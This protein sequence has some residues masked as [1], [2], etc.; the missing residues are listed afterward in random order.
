[1]LI[2]PD[3]GT[4][5]SG[6]N[7]TIVGDMG[8]GTSTT[9]VWTVVFPNNQTYNILVKASGYDSLGSPCAVSQTTTETVVPEFPSLLILPLLMAATLTIIVSRRKRASRC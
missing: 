2:L 6:N 8:G 3:G 7:E 5:F 9:I 4:I 1:V